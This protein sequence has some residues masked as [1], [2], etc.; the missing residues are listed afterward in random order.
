MRGKPPFSV[1]GRAHRG[2]RPARGRVH[3]SA[4][5]TWTRAD[6]GGELRIYASEPAFLLP[7]AGRRRPVD[8]GDPPALPRSGDA[9][10]TKPARPRTT[11]P[12]RS[13]RTDNTNWT[14]KLKAGYKF[15]NG[16]AVNADSFIRGWNFAAV[17]PDAQNNAYFMSRIDGLEDVSAVRTPTVRP[18][19]DPVRSSPA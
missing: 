18:A 1:G 10:T 12:S 17:R 5:T 11:W 19:S 7:T 15:T 4:R 13:S 2:H 9:T 16:E 14:I 8:P 6:A 3:V